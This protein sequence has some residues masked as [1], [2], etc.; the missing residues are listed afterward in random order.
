MLFFFKEIIFIYINIL[1][2]LKVDLII[3]PLYQYKFFK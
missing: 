2:N 3:N 1:K